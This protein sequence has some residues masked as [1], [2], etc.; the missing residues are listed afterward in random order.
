MEYSSR[1]FQSAE[2][3]AA[4][5]AGRSGALRR[6]RVLPSRDGGRRSEKLAK[7]GVGKCVLFGVALT[8]ASCLGARRDSAKASLSR[9]EMAGAGELGRD[10]V[11]GR[12]S[13][14]DELRSQLGDYAVRLTPPSASWKPVVPAQ[15][16]SIRG[17]RP[18][19]P[20]PRP[21]EESE[22]VEPETERDYAEPAPPFRTEPR[23]GALPLLPDDQQAEASSAPKVKTN[24]VAPRYLA[25]PTAGIVGSQPIPT[26][27]AGILPPPPPPFPAGLMKSETTFMPVIRVERVLVP[28]GAVPAPPAEN[29]PSAGP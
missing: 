17:V 3:G 11:E 18:K 10:R 23:K 27:P 15:A 12:P 20:T 19:T 13:I 5:A 22:F 26:P 9:E 1:G 2:A 7:Q 8:L 6:R 29:A 25:A 4:P 21:D 14:G 28:Q 16:R 24:Y